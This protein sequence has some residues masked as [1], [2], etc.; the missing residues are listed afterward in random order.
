MFVSNVNGNFSINDKPFR[1]IGSNVYELA[2]VDA[3]TTGKIIEDTAAAGFRVLR[4]WL[5]KNKE[6]SLMIK[7]LNEICDFVKPYGIK[8]IVSLS[9]KWGYLQDY[10]IDGEWYKNGYKHEYLDYVKAVTCECKSRD[11]IMIWELINEPETDSF[12]AFYEFAKNTSV[13][14]KSVNSNHMLSIGTVGGVG[15]KFGGYFSIFKK[16][17][18]VKLYS[19]SSLDAV[20]IHDYSYDSSVFERL[21]I[22]Y[23]FKG[24]EKKAKLFG[25]VDD[26]IDILFDKV[27]SWYLNRDKIIRIPLT[28]RGV[29][30][31]YNKKDIS[32]ADK[33]KKPVYIGEVG[34]KSG[35]KRD[36]K[37]ILELDIA[38]KFS[39][40]VSGYMLWSFEAQ[41]W[42]KDGH[43]YGFGLND[44]YGEIVKKWNEKLNDNS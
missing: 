9:D 21:D 26:T 12:N 8:L 10:K 20:S 11:E 13:E 7:K 37:K 16:S 29:W 39:L 17:N 19:L 30:N 4:F 18:F 22:L 41:G 25:K 31:R 35:M 15:D 6:T 23:R 36:R 14:I 32:F 1:F 38:E 5:F 2:N 24:H 34:F 43:S 3:Q 42:S 33:I 44:G 40:G 27:D 28:L